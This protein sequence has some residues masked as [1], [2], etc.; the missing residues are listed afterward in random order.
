MI[1]SLQLLGVTSAKNYDEATKVLLLLH[2]SRTR[3]TSVKV[4][5]ENRTHELPVIGG[6]LYHPRG[7]EVTL[8]PGHLQGLHVPG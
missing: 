7:Y 1:L 2:A 4:L 6:A 8:E 5:N 3:K